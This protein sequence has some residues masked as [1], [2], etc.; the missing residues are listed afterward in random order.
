MPGP[1]EHAP[2]AAPYNLTMALEAA[3]SAILSVAAPIIGRRDAAF[4]AFGK[5]QEAGDEVAMLAAIADKDQAEQDLRPF[6]RALA[7]LEGK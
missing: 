4:L 3:M 7:A 6:A 2:L 5:A 1:F